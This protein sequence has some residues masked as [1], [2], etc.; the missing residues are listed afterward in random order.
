MSISI[1]SQ[2]GGTP[3]AVFAYN[4]PDKIANLMSYL[5]ACDGFVDRQVKIFVDGPKGETDRSQVE[6]VRE[7]VR[8]L[9]LPNVTYSFQEVNRGLRNSIFAG[10]TDVIAEYGRTIVLEDDL[11]LSPISLEYFDKALTQ[12]ESE[13]RV[14]S[15]AGYAFDAQE[16]KHS[17]ACFALPFTHPWGWATWGRAWTRFDLNSRP[18]SKDLNARSFKA[19]FDMDG[20]YPFTKQL[21]NSLSGRVDSWSV[22]WYYTVFRHG[23]V[24]IFPPRRVV[25]NVGL[26]AGTHG[27]ALNPYDHL[28]RRP[29]LLDE[30]PDFC[31]AHHI[32]YTAMDALQR[33]RE[34]KVHRAIAYA[35]NAKRAV[36]RFGR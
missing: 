2:G 10:V 11:I 23:G 28:V 19:A 6:A 14:W 12:Y 20:I 36:L 8:H 30:M 7:F 13:E 35:G 3:V 34:L 24:S 33:C 21:K 1:R 25:D 27:G 26:N 9:A 18:E 29:R 22:H 17:K 16:L 31:D 32:D 15:I 5:Q 4:R